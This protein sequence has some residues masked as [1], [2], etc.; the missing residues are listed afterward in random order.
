MSEAD[1]DVAIFVGT[2]ETHWITRDA[3]KSYKKV[4]SIDVEELKWHPKNKN[5]FMA[6]AYTPACFKWNDTIE[7]CRKVYHDGGGDDCDA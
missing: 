7:P 3:G 1:N 4:E 6:T 2:Y 5:I